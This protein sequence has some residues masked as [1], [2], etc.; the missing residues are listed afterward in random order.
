MFFLVQVLRHP[1]HA[2]VGV[3]LWAHHE[4]IVVVD[5]SYAFFGGIDL[6]YGRWDD[7]RHRLTDLGSI[8]TGS[9]SGS[10]MGRSKRGTTPN[11]LPPATNQ[12]DVVRKLPQLAPGDPLM[13]SSTP[14][15]YNTAPSSD[16]DNFDEHM[17]QDTPE[18]E[19]KNYL[20]KIK[21]SVKTKGKDF[22]HRLT[23]NDPNDLASR[24]VPQSPVNSNKKYHLN[25]KHL[26]FG[27]EEVAEGRKGGAFAMSETIAALPPQNEILTTLDGQAKYWM[28][29][30]YTNFILKDFTNLDA[31]YADLVDRSVTPRMPWH[32]IG[33][34]VA[35]PVARDMARHFIQRWNAV[36]LE[37]AR[38][39]VL[40]PYLIPKSYGDIIV[41]E[42]LLN[43]PLQRVSCQV[44]RSVSSWN[45]GFIES[46]V[47]EQSIHEAYIQTIT[48]AEHYVY[49]ENQFFITLEQG[50]PIVKNQVGE[51]LYNR[52]LRAHKQHKV[53]RVYVVM[54]LLP[55]FEGDVGGT[56]GNSLRA[57]THW[58]YASISRGK[59]SIIQ[60]LKAAGIEDTSQYISF[61][62][63]RTHSMLD[64]SPVTELI[65]VHSK[66][67]IVDDRVVICGSANINDRSLIGMR[68][69]EI[70]CILTDEHFKAGRMNGV[71]FQSGLFA[72]GLRRY[73]FR[74]HLGL[75]EG[76]P[77]RIP[78][79]ITDPTIDS[80]WIGQ[81]QRTSQR[82]TL[83][84][85]EVFR[86]IPTDEVTT[87]SKLKRYVE[88]P[89]LA[90]TDPQAAIKEIQ[91][92]QVGG[93]G[94]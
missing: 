37:K 7:Y 36:K 88:E 69:S 30:D 34:V 33:G 31:P 63:L 47:V 3:F 85:D 44:I 91:R 49:I 35:G 59:S 80:F 83:V 32:D 52:I 67:M 45:C 73:L 8:A 50:N 41:M 89:S 19:R 72:G 15:F 39:N 9:T 93:K 58:N 21:D 55:G 81:W 10:F 66:L 43:V 53:F 71:P 40:Y 74:E 70:A 65:Y 23:L 62:S 68:D 6:C 46:E 82:N 38:D 92:I 90:K 48:S 79:D 54:P 22:M 4:K 84:F 24:S 11:N 77:D 25:P 16:P 2:R 14:N 64:S 13:I 29:K 17:K 20:G 26:F 28:G 27:D 60:R 61:H 18:M 56:T 76:D 57:I 75:I 86:C 78:I 12:P 94:G 42:Q 87:F 51:A 1:D 5:Q